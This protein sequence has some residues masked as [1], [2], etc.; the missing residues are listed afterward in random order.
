MTLQFNSLINGTF[1]NAVTVNEYN[2]KAENTIIPF[3]C[4]LTMDNIDE[5][6][7]YLPTNLLDNELFLNSDTS[8]LEDDVIVKDNYYTKMSDIGIVTSINYKKNREQIEKFYLSKP[9]YKVE[10]LLEIAVQM[11]KHLPKEIIETLDNQLLKDKVSEF[12]RSILTIDTKRLN[13]ICCKD[14]LTEKD[15]SFIYLEDFN[16]G[17]VVYKIITYTLVFILKYLYFRDVFE[18]NGEL[19]HLSNYLTNIAGI[20]DNKNQLKEENTTIFNQYIDYLI[21]FLRGFYNLSL[22]KKHM[23]NFEI[24]VD[25]LYLS[26]LSIETNLVEIQRKIDYLV[27]VVEY[28]LCLSNTANITDDEWNSYKFIIDD[29]IAS[30]D[31]YKDIFN[32]LREMDLN[33]LINLS[34]SLPKLEAKNSKGRIS[35]YIVNLIASKLRSCYSV[36]NEHFTNLKQ[37]NNKAIEDISNEIYNN[38]N[39]IFLPPKNTSA[40]FEYIPLVPN[41]SFTDTQTQHHHILKI[42][43]MFTNSCSSIVDFYKLLFKTISESTKNEELFEWLFKYINVSEHIDKKEYIKFNVD[44]EKIMNII[45]KIDYLTLNTSSSSYLPSYL[46]IKS[47]ISNL[48]KFDNLDDIFV[49]FIIKEKFTEKLKEFYINIQNLNNLFIYISYEKEFQKYVSLYNNID[50]SKY[51]QYINNKYEILTLDRDISLY[52]SLPNISNEVLKNYLALPTSQS[53]SLNTEYFNDLNKLEQSIYDDYTFHCNLNSSC[54]IPNAKNEID[55]TP[56]SELYEVL[57]DRFKLTAFNQQNTFAIFQDNSNGTPIDKL[58]Q[59]LTGQTE[60]MLNQL[61][62]YSFNP[63]DYVNR[64]DQMENINL[65]IFTRKLCFEIQKDSISSDKEINFSLEEFQD[66]MQNS[67]HYS[68]VVNTIMSAS[69]TS[70]TYLRN[71]VNVNSLKFN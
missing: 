67:S 34:Y 15:I 63:F 32:I 48:Y 9:S 39:Y 4:F 17:T 62:Y 6:G 13:H 57:L 36:F 38:Q 46:N 35:K 31:E 22:N 11:M 20:N 33:T 25:I 23:L 18:D 68:E 19:V 60:E 41:T 59:P 70:N 49:N 53:L 64:F 26:G 52:N 3:D 65:K 40:S 27:S 51:I 45:Y 24:D 28:S 43:E 69:G 8:L 55:L 50:M 30:I 2:G 21:Y 1:I 12:H 56:H 54:K 47:N 7:I 42:S 58:H 10:D 61:G 5:R 71:N 44:L 37:P 16:T 66:M 14:I 29:L